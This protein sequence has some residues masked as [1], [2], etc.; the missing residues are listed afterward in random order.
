MGNYVSY[1][2]FICAILANYKQTISFHEIIEIIN[3]Y[4]KKYPY[5]I[6]AQD[7]IRYI[8]AII[9][10]DKEHIWLK[11]EYNLD[12]KYGY[13]DITLKDDLNCIGGTKIVDFICCYIS[14]NK[15]FACH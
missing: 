2:Q 13:Y 6:V 3:S 15:N 12:N 1:E 14:E 5:D 4:R 10:H 7:T 11:R 9:E 8:N